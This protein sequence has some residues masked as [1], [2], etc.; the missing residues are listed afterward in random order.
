MIQWEWFPNGSRQGMD[1]ETI[2]KESI[3]VLS[4]CQSVSFRG[5]FAKQRGKNG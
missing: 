2:N 1:R 5:F 4:S 3:P